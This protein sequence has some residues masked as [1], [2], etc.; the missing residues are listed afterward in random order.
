M[1][2]SS[3]ALSDAERSSKT[4]ERMRQLASGAAGSTTASG[5][6]ATLIDDELETLFSRFQQNRADMG[7]KDGGKEK[8]KDRGTG[9]T[10]GVTLSREKWMAEERKA[11]RLRREE[12]KIRAL[13]RNG[14]VDYCIQE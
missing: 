1:D 9:P 6:E 8:E 11:Q 14:R 5:N 3:Q 4:A 13:N 2:T 12:M 10:G 7:D